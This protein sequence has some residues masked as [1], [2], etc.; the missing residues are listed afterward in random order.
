[1]AKL[2]PSRGGGGQKLTFWPVSLGSQKNDTQIVKFQQEIS[3]TTVCVINILRL[4]IANIFCM[5]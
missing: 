4:I 5:E 1:M 3:H 2:L